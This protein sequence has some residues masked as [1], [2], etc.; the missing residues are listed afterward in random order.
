MLRAIEKIESRSFFNA[1]KRGLAFV[2]FALFF[3]LLPSA[4]LADGIS[5]YRAHYAVCVSGRSGDER[6]ALRKFRKNGG[7]FLLLVEPASLRT[8]IA[9]ASSIRCASDTAENIR[10]R[11]SSS[12][13]VRAIEDS[14]RNAGKLQNAG[15][16]RLLPFGKGINLTVDLCP[17]TLPLDRVL[18]TRILEEFAAIERPVPLG[19]SVT[20]LWMNDH[21][22]DIRW[23]VGLEGSGLIAI[24][25]INHS[26]NHRYNRRLPLKSNF[27]L[28]K[29]T[30]LDYEVL[31]TERKMIENGLTPSVFFRFPGLV[32]DRAL[33]NIITG[34]GLLPLGS[35][36]W[37]GKRQWPGSGSIVLVHANGREPIGIVRFLELLRARKKEIV[38]GQWHLYDLRDSVVEHERE[39][40]K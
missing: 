5:G 28:E 32:S 7:D 14:R 10:H 37:L 33:V 1:R 11:F 39:S 4:A 30:D 23:L 19:L 25:W 12:F 31:A 27:L 2:V 20:G 18:F 17:S 35:D 29:G 6:L 22:E 15:F 13:Y 3:G 34:Y 38:N 16:T 9:P 36:A 24:T 21:E 40:A 8:S 26:Y